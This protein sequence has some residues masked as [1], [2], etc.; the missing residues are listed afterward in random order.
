M[1]FHADFREF[2]PAD[3][4]GNE[5]VLFSKSAKICA[6]VCEHLRAINPLN[7]VERLDA[8]GR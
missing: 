1:L 3:L 4:R 5:M 8:E 2:L 7:I 6:S